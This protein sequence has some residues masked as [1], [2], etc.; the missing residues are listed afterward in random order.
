MMYFI[1]YVVL[2]LLTL[3]GSSIITS[4]F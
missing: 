2:R 1:G 4:I 3:V